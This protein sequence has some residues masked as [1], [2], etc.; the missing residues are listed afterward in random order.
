MQDPVKVYIPSIA[1]GSLIIY[2]GGAMPKWKGNLF[3]GALKIKH[4]NRVVVDKA[5]KEI[6]E[7]RLL[8]S[9]NERIRA[10]AE[11]PEGWLY[12]STDSG[13]IYRIRPK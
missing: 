8:T 12:F 5:A 7:E 6:K 11:S 10:L 3:S 1:P 4:I 13:N 2:N 9:M